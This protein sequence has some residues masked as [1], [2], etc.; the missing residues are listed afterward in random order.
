MA[1]EVGT[2]PRWGFSD[3]TGRWNVAGRLYF[4]RDAARD[5]PKTVYQDRDG[6]IPHTNPIILDGIGS[7]GAIFFNDDEPYYITMTDSLGTLP[8]IFEYED[9]V[10][11]LAAGSGGSGSV[12]S[13][14]I[15]YVINGQFRFFFENPI[16]N[17]AAGELQ[18]APYWFFDKSN[19]TGTDSI[20]F[21]PFTLGSD[22]PPLNPTYYCRY[23]CTGAPTGE[24]YKDFYI[25]IK[26]VNA[27]QNEVIT[28]SVEEKGTSAIQQFEF[29]YLQHFGTGGTPSVDVE[30]SISADFITADW[31]KISSTVTL[32]SIAGMTLGTNKDDYLA[33]IIR[34]PLDVVTQFDFTNF[35]VNLGDT[36]LSYEYQTYDKAKIEER[37]VNYPIYRDINGLVTEQNAADTTT[38]ITINEGVCADSTGYD[39]F[40]LRSA[41][42]K[43]ITAT[44]V[45]GDSV[46]GLATGL[47]I[48]ADTWYHNFL[49]F[50]PNGKVDSGTDT[51]LT[52]ANLLAS[53]AVQSAGYILYRRVASFRTNGSSLIKDYF[54]THD[55]FLWDDPDN[56]TSVTM[57]AG[58]G[59]L[60]FDLD[61]PPG[62]RVEAILN[63]TG[64]FQDVTYAM[65][66]FVT[67]QPPILRTG[68][69]L[70]TY[71]TDNI[72][73]A[74][75]GGKYYLI[76][77]DSQQIR[78]SRSSTVAGRTF[79][80]VTLGWKDWRID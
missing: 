3:E 20:T 52:A 55:T 1:F 72:V 35:Q 46:G 75:G 50:S 64:L 44:W 70:Y 24:T 49:L 40:R 18:I 23:D 59:S 17:P 77:N 34:V 66:P 71:S 30:G 38:L 42:T 48:A 2:I 37:S 43:D 16:T 15:N 33:L 68:N 6:L 5:Q 36:V 60:L 58:T 14:N 51:S 79:E 4:W 39:L 27:F 25:K 19:A 76:T 7:V 78:Q 69:P 54:Q 8:P 41:L 29:R 63:M 32:P 61:V 80:Y 26:D 21:L 56:F 10:P 11:T 53:A 65:P 62:F 9:Y 74:R 57:I 22:T 12:I 28:I 13:S 47:T 31:T 73:P 67:D 45:E